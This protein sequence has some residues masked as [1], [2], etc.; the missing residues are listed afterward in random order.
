MLRRKTNKALKTL[1]ALISATSDEIN[2]LFPRSLNLSI[3]LRNRQ[4]FYKIRHV[5]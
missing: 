2:R 1:E 3:I 4:G 5:G